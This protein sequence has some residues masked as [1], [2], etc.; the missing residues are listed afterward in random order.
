MNPNKRTKKNPYNIFDVWFCV[1][2]NEVWD[3]WFAIKRNS[4]P[5]PVKAFIKKLQLNA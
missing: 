3:F 5:K 1:P 2:K 4:K